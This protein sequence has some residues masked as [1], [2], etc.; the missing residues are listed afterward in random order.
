MASSTWKEGSFVPNSDVILTS[1]GWQNYVDRSCLPIVDSKIT[2]VCDSNPASSWANDPR[3]GLDWE[4]FN[5]TAY[6]LDLVVPV[7]NLGQT[8]TWSP[9]RD[10]GP[11]GYMLWFSRWWFEIAGWVIATAA[12]GLLTGQ[13]KPRSE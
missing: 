9:S 10:R 13:I 1:S 11:W 8:S 4:G 5:P 7:L 3:G 12:A 2:T 6:A